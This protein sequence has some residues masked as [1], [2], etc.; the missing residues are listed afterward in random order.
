MSSRQGKRKNNF[1]PLFSDILKSITGSASLKIAIKGREILGVSLEGRSITIDVKDPF[2]VLDLGVEEF[3]KKKGQS[4]TA[5]KL[6]DAGFRVIL[7]Y[8]IFRVEL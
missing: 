5:K 4:R 1:M 8:K 6:K 3:L 2:A 7:K